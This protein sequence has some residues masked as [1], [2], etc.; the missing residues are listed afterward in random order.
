MKRS[1]LSVQSD[2][3]YRFTS[4]K[5][6]GSALKSSAKTTCVERPFRGNF[7]RNRLSPKESSSQSMHTQMRRKNNRFSQRLLIRIEPF[8]RAA[9]KRLLTEIESNGARCSLLHSL[10]HACSSA[11][12][13]PI[14]SARN[15]IIWHATNGAREWGCTW[16][17][18]GGQGI[19]FLCGHFGGTVCLN[20]FQE[21]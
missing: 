10:R 15:R 9:H 14:T 4:H 11:I 1:P 18:K 21:F 16:A 17:T 20:N 6:P 12:A 2:G 19:L 3:I 8:N 7:V 13:S 5:Q